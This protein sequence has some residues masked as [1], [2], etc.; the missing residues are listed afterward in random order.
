MNEPVHRDAP[1]IFDLCQDVLGYTFRDP[2]YLKSALTHASGADHR[3][4]S[5]ERLEFLGDAILGAIVCELLYLKFPEYL[6]GELTRIKS[7]V[8]SRRTCAKISER[9]GFEEF[10]ILGKGMGSQE[11]TPS[12]VLADVFESLV[13]AIYLDGGMDAAKDFIVRHIEAEIDETVDGHMGVNHK[14]NLQ[15]VAQRQFGETPTYLLLDEKGPD[16]SKCFK[17]SAQIG[18]HHY[19]PAWG[20]N[21]KDAEQRAALNALSQLSGEPIPFESE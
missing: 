1:S 16:H 11:Q 12:S 13:G 3:L 8:V 20:R 6:E 7:V 17:I 15:Q 19:P 9:L 10:L 18:K 21:K 5:N 4:S 14:S 2:G